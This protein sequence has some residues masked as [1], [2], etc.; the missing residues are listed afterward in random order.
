MKLLVFQDVTLPP[1]TTT[2]R[3]KRGEPVTTSA[4]PVQLAPLDADHPPRL[5]V[6]VEPP[7]AIGY[8]TGIA[9]NEQREDYPSD[10][11]P[12][13][14]VILT[15]DSFGTHTPLFKEGDWVHLTFRSGDTRPVR[16]RAVLQMH[17][18]R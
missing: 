10:R 8:L 17:A 16:V 18:R 12:I 1:R 15:E 9:I 5:V 6:S 2:P 14:F 7:D 4:Q 3:S 11:E 13:T